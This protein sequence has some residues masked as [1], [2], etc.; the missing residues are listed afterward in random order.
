MGKGGGE[1]PDEQGRLLAMREKAQEEST[2]HQAPKP[3]ENPSTN[4]M[5]RRREGVIWGNIEHRIR[6]ERDFPA[7][8]AQHRMG[9]KRTGKRNLEP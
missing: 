3:R 6:A 7:S 4:G 2:K 8:N 5:E 9:R 1:P